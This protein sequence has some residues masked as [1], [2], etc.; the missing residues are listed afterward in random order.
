MPSMGRTGSALDNAISEMFRGELKN[1]PSLPAHRFFSREAAK[2][3]AF[4]YVESFYNRVRRHSSLG[5]LG[6]SGHEQAAM[7]EVAV[8]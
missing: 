3:A 6:S 5:Y 4:Y 1:R 7:E 2:I 8:A